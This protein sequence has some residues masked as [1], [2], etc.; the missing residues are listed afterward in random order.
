[1]LT[2]TFIPTHPTTH[3]LHPPFYTKEELSSGSDHG[4]LRGV[5]TAPSNDVINIS[6]KAFSPTFVHGQ[7]LY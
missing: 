5:V 6:S 2:L 7:L 3:P 1:M 4:N